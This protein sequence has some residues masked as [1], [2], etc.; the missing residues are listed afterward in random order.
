MKKANQTLAARLKLSVKDPALLEQ[1]LT[2]SSY[3]HVHQVESNERLEFLGDAILSAIVA[4]ELYKKFPQLNEGELTRRRAQCVQG[5]RLAA[6]AQKLGLPEYFRVHMTSLSQKTL[7][8]LSEQAFEALVGALWLQL[9][10]EKTRAKVLAWLP[11]EG[12]G[13]TGFNP[14]GLLQERL[15]PQ[16][17]VEKIE[18]KLV[19]QQGPNHDRS[20]TVELWVSGKKLAQGTGKSKKEAE[21]SAAQAALKKL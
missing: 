4:D 16:I 17:S 11:M 15:Q 8:N 10:W 7:D 21:E 2:H 3:A 18:Y 5:A 20:F 13:N 9:G 12:P 1:A 6:A 19:S 14:K